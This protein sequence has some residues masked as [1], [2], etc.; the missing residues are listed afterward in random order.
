MKITFENLG[1]IKNTTV[2]LS[3]DLIILCG[4]NNT[5]KTY[6]AYAVFGL[7]YFVRNTDI[8]FTQK[9]FVDEA[10]MLLF[11][12][13]STRIDLMELYDESK[14]IFVNKLS[15]QYQEYLPTVFSSK[16]D[17]FSDTKV[18]I[19]FNAQDRE[20][21][22]EKLLDSANFQVMHFGK[23]IALTLQKNEKDTTLNLV[24]TKEQNEE[25]TKQYQ[26]IANFISDII[27]NEVYNLLYK[28]IFNNSYIAPAERS[29]VNIF[30]KELSEKRNRLV[31]KLLEYNKKED[32]LEFIKNEA[33]RYPLPIKESLDIAG[34]LTHLQKRTSVFAD[35]AKQMESDILKGSI[36]VTKTGEMQFQPKATKVSLGIHLSA[37][38]VKSL[39]SIV[40]YC[41]H[42]AMPQDIIIIDEPELNLHPD[43]QRIIAKIIAQLINRGVKVLI[44]THSDYIIRELNNLIML[45]NIKNDTLIKKNI[46]KKYK[47]KDS[48]LLSSQKIAVHL[49]TVDS[50]KEL[51]VANN[52]FAIATID[53]QINQ[54]NNAADE[55]LLLL[56]DEGGL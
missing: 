48:Q 11:D 31:D 41:R 7:L 56:D 51:D 19:E 30:S 1:V 24:L 22:L 9:G 45:N 38:I 35:I 54:L 46:M 55:I 10:L 34:N 4:E 36:K 25:T 18:I 49:F 17:Y 28:T 12:T 37:S 43:N 27:K 20:S 21:L 5:G 14:E 33:S 47:Y 8:R 32:P 53:E 15:K 23:T 42:L 3:K 13:G 50:V 52:G 44:S 40:F 16:S 6:L 29:S 26:K 39:S 2:D